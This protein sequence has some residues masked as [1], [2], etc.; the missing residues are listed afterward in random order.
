MA[1][2][3]ITLDDVVKA[4]HCVSGAKAWF[5]GHGFDWRD[6]V[7]N[8]VSE[9]D[10]LATGDGLAERVIAATKARADG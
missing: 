10:L 7:R 1:G 8:G 6:V 3:R 4:G 5:V 2:A 9:A